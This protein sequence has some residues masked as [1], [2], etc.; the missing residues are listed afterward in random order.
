[1]PRKD[2]MDTFGAVSLVLFAALFGFNQ[3]VIKVG[4][5]G[6]QP[7]FFAGLRSILALP[8]ILV[9]MRMRGIPL[10]I[11][12]G[13]VPAGLL[14]GAFFS[15]EFLSLFLAL[16]LTT[17][18]RLSVIFYS[19]PIWMALG[20]HLF[21]PGERLTRRKSLGLA[22]AFGGVAWAILDRPHGQAEA[23]LL[24]DLCALA[25]AMAWAGIGVT[26]R[27]SAL[28]TQRPEMQLLWQ[29]G[30]SAVVLTLA[31]LGFGP[32][33]REVGAIHLAALAFQVVV[34]AFMAYVFWLWMLTIYPASSVAAFSFLGPIF[35]VFFGWLLL[36]E[37]IGPSL[38][39]ALA[40]VAAGLWL[41]SRPRRRAVAPA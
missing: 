23:S 18:T 16:D 9:W 11:A 36:G 29:L 19:M 40:L 31:S 14:I 13:T 12:Q 17:V 37:S 28:R 33:L 26:A 20:A 10:Q 7:V 1:M 39:G 5:E 15:I 21:L 34:I 30:V 24:G 2:Q 32:L 4:N 8:L 3:V 35:G 38:L 6:F 27:A 25:G 41:I 22:L